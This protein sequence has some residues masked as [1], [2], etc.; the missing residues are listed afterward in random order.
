M[1]GHVNG[2]VI[3]H[4]LMQDFPW[5]SFVGIFYRIF[6]AEGAEMVTVIAYF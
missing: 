4:G 6:K 3:Y 2:Y 5:K 1:T